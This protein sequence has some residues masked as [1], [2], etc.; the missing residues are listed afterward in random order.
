MET[1]PYKAV[2]ANLSPLQR[3][4]RSHQPGVWC[5]GHSWG[6]ER[7]Y[8]PLVLIASEHGPETSSFKGCLQKYP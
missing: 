5:C 6:R 3:T 2:E 7:N 1:N 4:G 8:P